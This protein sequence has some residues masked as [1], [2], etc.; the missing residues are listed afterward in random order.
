MRGSFVTSTGQASARDFEC[1]GDEGV[2]TDPTVPP[3]NVGCFCKPY[4]I[5]YERTS[6]G[7]SAS[8]CLSLSLDRKISPGAQQKNILARTSRLGTDQ[9]K[10]GLSAS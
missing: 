7:W 2:R 6:R 3:L 8:F 9:K 4:L 5:C 1:N 10:R